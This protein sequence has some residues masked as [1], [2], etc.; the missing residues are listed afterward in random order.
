MR[1]LDRL[2]ISSILSCDGSRRVLLQEYGKPVRFAGK[3]MPQVTNVV[4]SQPMSLAE[5]LLRKR[6]AA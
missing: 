2:T 6:L 5:K 3:L 1:K 4:R